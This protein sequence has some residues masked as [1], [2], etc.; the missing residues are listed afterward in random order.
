MENIEKK[1]LKLTKEEDD[2]NKLSQEIEELTNSEDFKKL[3]SKDKVAL[4]AVATTRI[5][6]KNEKIDKDS[7]AEGLTIW[8]IIRYLTEIEMP[9][10]MIDFT[11]ILYPGNEKYF[12]NIL[13]PTAFVMIQKQAELLIK[14]KAYEDEKHKQHLEKI[15]NGQMPY[16]YSLEMPTAKEDN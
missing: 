5:G 6:L 13:T 10:K 8:R 16:G 4:M 3:D 12:S 9:L 15:I 2:V 7:N 14:N 11:F 1:F